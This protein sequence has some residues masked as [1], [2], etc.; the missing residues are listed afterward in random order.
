MKRKYTFVKK[1]DTVRFLS[2]LLDVTIVH[3]LVTVL[4]GLNSIAL[5]LIG[6]TT[7]LNLATFTVPEQIKTVDE[8]VLKSN[9]EIK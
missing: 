4:F 7:K 3:L 2:F 8:Q 1:S 9:P 6:Y 5:L